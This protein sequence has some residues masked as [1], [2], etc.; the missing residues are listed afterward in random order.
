MPANKKNISKKSKVRFESFLNELKVLLKKSSKN[1]DPGRWLYDNEARKTVFML[2]ALSKIYSNLYSGKKFTKL[3]FKFKD[4]EDAF[5]EID[6]YD[7]F[8]KEFIQ[9][10]NIPRALVTHLKEQ[11]KIKTSK[12]NKLLKK[13]WTKKNLKAISS[14][15]KKIQWLGEEEEVK[16]IK[17]YY[18]QEI[19][20]ITN[21][22]GNCRFKSIEKDVHELRR[23]VRWLSIYC[24]ALKGSVQLI[25][26]KSTHPQLAK[27]LT[28]ETLSSPFNKSPDADDNKH[29]VLLE[30]NYFYALSWLVT[31][32]GK[33]K[34]SGLKIIVIKDFFRAN[35][36]SREKAFKK[37]YQLLG[38]NYPELEKILTDS[39]KICDQFFD[40][41]ILDHLVIGTGEALPG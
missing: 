6:F 7:A 16:K 24:H 22:S 12:V 17:E 35:G 8:E 25:K 5:G 18:D 13:E 3:R 10:P 9:N 33:L 29:F 21:H 41:G 28:K 32:L 1:P 15:L 36:N 4:L 37:T 2:E 34:D 14:G 30:Q 19:I 31:E 40:D 39:E 38:S 26:T 11:T 23:K 27:Y 20:K